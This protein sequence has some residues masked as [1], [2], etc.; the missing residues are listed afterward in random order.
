MG[1]HGLLQR[2][3]YLLVIRL[4]ASIN[5]GIKNG[6]DAR[7]VRQ[8]PEMHNKVL[9]GKREVKRQPGKPV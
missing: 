9:T 4:P 7:L 6:G 8:A 1:L 5:G 2:E 3:L